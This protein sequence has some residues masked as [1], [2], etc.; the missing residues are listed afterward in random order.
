MGLSD[1]VA[2]MYE[3]RIVAV[4]PRS[5]CTVNGLGLLMAGGEAET[6]A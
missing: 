4:V 2:V 5:E 6:A 3:G 1:E